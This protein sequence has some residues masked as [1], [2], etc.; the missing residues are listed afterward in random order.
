MEE[1]T[2]SSKSGIPN[3]Q[4]IGDKFEAQT[5]DK[6]S[7]KTIQRRLKEREFKW[8]KN[9]KKPFVSEKNRLSRLLFAR[10]RVS[11]SI[12]EWKSIVLNPIENL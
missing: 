5:G 8:R 11:L 10:E 7:A 1:I 9:S 6:D 2:R 3:K 12:D 4:Q